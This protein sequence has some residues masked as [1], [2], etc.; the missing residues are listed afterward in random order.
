[1]KKFFGLLIAMVLSIPAYASITV[2]PTKIELNANKVR[3]NYATCAVE[4]KG[5]AEKAM[6]FKAYSGYFKV[7]DKSELVLIE[8]KGDPYDISSKVRFVPSEFTI[9]PGKS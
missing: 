2:S 5:D 8:E 4:I 9:P 3:N 6:R 7:S 1:M